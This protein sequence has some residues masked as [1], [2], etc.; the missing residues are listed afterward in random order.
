MEVKLL[1]E[2]KGRLEKEGSRYTVFYNTL[3]FR[4]NSTIEIEISGLSEG[5]F[6]TRVGC[7]SCTT[8]K[9]AK[10]DEN[11]ILTITYDT[12]NIGNFNKTVTFFHQEQPTIFNIKGIVTR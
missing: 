4:Q 10:K 1:T 3:T 12:K 5:D 8:A 7:T 9:A 11:I 6:S 2:D